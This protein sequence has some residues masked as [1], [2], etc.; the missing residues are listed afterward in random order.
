MLKIFIY[1]S[2]ESIWTLEGVHVPRT[3]DLAQIYLDKLSA[4][5]YMVSTVCIMNLLSSE[6]PFLTGIEYTGKSLNFIL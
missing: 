2:C 5:S 3:K 1:Y 4:I 6:R